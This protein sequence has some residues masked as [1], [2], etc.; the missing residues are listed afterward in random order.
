MNYNIVYRYFIRLDANNIPVE[1]SLVRR[2]KKPAGRFIDITEA[3]V[4]CCLYTT[5]TT[6]TTEAP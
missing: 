6:T 3:V 5:T 1:G 4:Q 2:K